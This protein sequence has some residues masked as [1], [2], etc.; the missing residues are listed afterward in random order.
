MEAA[1]VD[2]LNTFGLGEAGACRSVWDLKDGVVLLRVLHEISPSH[3]ELSALSSSEGNWALSASNV[4]KLLRLVDEYY[5]AVLG[6][7]VGEID[8]IDAALIARDNDA[9]EMLSLVELVVGV[10]VMCPDKARFIQNIFALDAASQ[11]AL[12]GLVERVM[13]RTEDIASAAGGADDGEEES[14]RLQEMVRHLQAERARLSDQVCELER[15]ND[16]LTATTHALRSQVQQHESDREALEGSDRTRHAAVAARAEAL[17]MQLQDTQR[18]LDLAT[19]QNDT[20]R[21]DLRASQ[22]RAEGLQQVQARLE[23]DSRQLADELDVA[24]DRSNKLTKAEA[25]LDK[26]TR[27]LE[28]LAAVKREN[29]E[30]A[31]KL[32]QYIEKVRVRLEIEKEKEKEREEIDRAAI[33]VTIPPT[34]LSFFA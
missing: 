6:K 22:A 21:A 32:D 10:A 25:Q 11:S 20:L 7:R 16:A 26:Y 29:K 23:F 2:W 14:I 34:A 15:A 9:E 33:F 8:A 17:Q 28:E 12:K 13:Q 24:R 18:D 1:I 5:R 30:L 27:R 19:V 4:K 31:D 3:F